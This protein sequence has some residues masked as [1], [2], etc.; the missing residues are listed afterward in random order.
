[1]NPAPRYSTG[2]S[3]LLRST[4]EMGRIVKPGVLSGGEYWYDV[5][6]SKRPEKVPEEDLEPLPAD[7]T[8]L[9]DLVLSGK[10]G[11]IGAFRTAVAL[12]RLTAPDQSTVYAFR[13]QRVLFEPF[14]YKPLLK[15]LDAPSRRLLIADEVGLGKTVEAGLILAELEARHQSLDRVVI[16]CPSRLRQKWRDELCRKFSQEFDV[17]GRRDFVE[18]IARTRRSGR[19]QRLRCIVSM[20]TA[21]DADLLAQIRDAYEPLDLL[22]VDEAHHARNPAAQLSQMLRELCEMSAAVVLLTATP[23]HLGNRDLFTLLNALR[24]TVFRDLGAFESM[25]SRHRAVHEASLTMRS[26][27]PARLPAVRRMLGDVFETG[28]DPDDRDPIA[29]AVI[30]ELG[31][32]APVDRGAWVEMERRIQELHPLSSILTRTRKRDVQEHAPVRRPQVL[33]CRFTPEEEEAYRRLVD[34]SKRVDWIETRLSLGQI[35]RARQA[36]SCLPAAL[37]ASFEAARTEDEAVEIT[38]LLP[39]GVADDESPPPIASIRLTYDSKFEKLAELLRSV[40]Q[41]EPGAKVLVFTFFVGTSVYL[42][43]ELTRRGF[44][45]ER[46]AGDVVSDPKNPRLDAR[47]NILRAFRD[48]PNLRVLVSTEVGSEGLDFQFCHHLVNYD[49]PWN[50]MVVEQRIGRIDR[51]GQTSDTLHILNLVVENTV[52]D[53]I[54]LALYERI[55]IFSR[56]LG[57]LE[58]ILGET[59]SDL[60]ADYVLGKLTPEEASRRV[61]AA[62]LAIE[63]RRADLEKLERDSSD[64]FG[65]EQYVKDQIDRVRRLGRFVSDVS[66]LAVIEAFLHSHHPSAGFWEEPGGVRKLRLTDGLK[67]SILDACPRDALWTDRSRGGVLSLC[68]DGEDAY[69]NPD[70]ELVNSTH[71]LVKASV[72]ALRV[73][74]DAVHARL[75]SGV[76]ALRADDELELAEGTYFLLAYAHIVEGIRTRK[77][78]DTICWSIADRRMLAADDG[79]RLLH[80]A[81]QRGEE[82]EGT[83]I[84][85]PRELWEQSEQEVLV[86]NRRLRAAEERENDA[87]YLRRK[88]LLEAEYRHERQRKEAR[89][90]DAESRG[91]VQIL[92]ALDGQIKKSEIRHQLRMEELEA[93]RRSGCRLEGPL[94]ACLVRVV[95]LAEKPRRRR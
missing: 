42:K 76:L 69:R 25:L 13:A 57:Q 44:R 27:D 18:H 95:R 7:E 36:A 32:A 70:V 31:G 17:F 79:E 43:N 40:D 14:Q 71:P 75:G 86:R 26:M 90:R 73:Q 53:R 87:L 94:A 55:G 46:I 6:F 1:M 54:L 84:A 93:T 52:E 85:V 65:L 37:A 28:I 16:V 15:F 68:F 59:F 80:L 10:W 83:P 20:Q 63:N 23:L 48:D 12:E 62:A 56:S 72:A 67:K 45:A 50:P 35:Q 60:Q 89:L 24:P 8:T 66:L 9:Q 39:T 58:S 91:Q 51:F 92:P 82:S 22:V 88:A 30:D 81:I 78:L 4:K 34:G 21:R 49:L 3:V 38:D 29:R 74:F 77:V 41:Q 11:R 5:R 64:L 19:R 2:D 33:R 61:E 47:G